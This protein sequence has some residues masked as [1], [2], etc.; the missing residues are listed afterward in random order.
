[1]DE[2][3]GRPEYLEIIEGKTTK[4]KRLDLQPL[5]STASVTDEVPRR[6]TSSRNEP[7]DKGELA[8][9]MVRDALPKIIGESGG[10]FH[11]EISNTHRSIGARPIWRNRKSKDEST[12]A[13]QDAFQGHCRAEFWCV[14]CRWPGTLS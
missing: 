10:E 13:D 6:C 14:E 4:Q 1:M 11:Y 5:L 12:G 3:I 8:E 2:L 7:W 9:Q